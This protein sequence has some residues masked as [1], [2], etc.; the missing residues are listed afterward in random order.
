MHRLF[1]VLS[2]LVFTSCATTPS[3]QQPQQ[4]EQTGQTGV[5]ALRSPNALTAVASMPRTIVEPKIRVG[6]LSDQPSVTF[7]RTSDG[8]YIV[9]EAGPSLI[10]RGFT[11]SAP[12]ANAT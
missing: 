7:P 2:L 6:L 9:T 8:Y 12:L 4:P 5:S 1:A 10:K 3:A 11:V